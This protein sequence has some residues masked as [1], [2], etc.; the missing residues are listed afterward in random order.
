MSFWKIFFGS[1][2]AFVVGTVLLFLLM[3]MFIAG[4][5]S[6][7]SNNEPT[8][9]KENSI[10]SL[11]L[12]YEI[13]EQTTYQPFSDFSFTDFEPSISP[14]LYDI[15]KNIEKAKDDDNIKGI[16]LT[17]GYIGAG[18]ATTDQVRNALVDFKKSGKFVVAYTELYTEKAYYL[19]SVAD[20]VIVNPKGVV[21]FNGTNAQYVFFKRLL[22]KIGVQ[23]QV[24]Y[25]GKFK[26]AT[27]P[28]RLD[29]MS[30]ENELMTFEL[31]N[32][33]H[34]RLIQNVSESRNLGVELTDSI[35]NNMLVQN[36]RD[37]KTYGLVDEVWF[38]DQVRDY[39]KQQLKLEKKDKINFVTLSKY[40]K[41]AGKKKDGTTGTD[42]IAVLFAAGDIVDG[43]GDDD[44][45]GSAKYIEQLRKLREDEKVKA[46]VFRVNSGGG[47]ALA[48]DII[49]REVELTAKEKPVVISMGDYAASGGYYIAALATK[50][51]AEPNTLTGSI[52]V[53]GILPNMQKLF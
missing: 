1:L 29:S 20:K 32:D 51:V 52:G 15:L 16:Y 12:S 41:V 2:T 36:A 24:F 7:F 3:I 19:C 46:I 25:D 27:E 49:A 39:F 42:K 35:N 11:N 26:S 53:F 43:R 47:S 30:K 18:M 10:L 40:M 21:E 33:I 4:I 23:P 34:K 8:T 13:P 28:F 14:G 38:D 48:S 45:I 31:I 9:T 50:I 37:A 44:N 5:A 6:L 22:D 17:F